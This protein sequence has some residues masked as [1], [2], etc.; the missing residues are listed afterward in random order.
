MVLHSLTAIYLIV[1]AELGL[2]PGLL[3]AVC[4][5]ESKHQVSS[6]RP[7]DGTADSI[8]V[9]QVQLPTARSLGYK[10]PGSALRKPETNIYWAGR[11]LSHQLDRYQDFAKAISAYNAGTARTNTK[12][13]LKN[14]K[15]VN[16]VMTAWEQG[17]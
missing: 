10:G 13:Q 6:Y 8:G 3:S 9:C 11:Y 17:R 12:G 15:Y 1:S 2:P 4:Y 5:V 7:A 14:R 16:L